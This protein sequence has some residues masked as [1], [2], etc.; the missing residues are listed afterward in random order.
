MNQFLLLLII[1]VCGTALICYRYF[2]HR[3]NYGDSEKLALI[4]KKASE[5]DA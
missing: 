5:D 4:D 3:K 2:S 1:I